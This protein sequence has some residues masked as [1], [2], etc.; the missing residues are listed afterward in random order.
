M[1]H[2]RDTISAIETFLAKGESP[3]LPQYFYLPQ[4]QPDYEQL[5]RNR[6]QMYRGTL[7]MLEKDYGAIAREAFLEQQ[8]KRQRRTSQ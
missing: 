1:K 4:H 8:R 7:E 5:A 3:P 2:A 6:I